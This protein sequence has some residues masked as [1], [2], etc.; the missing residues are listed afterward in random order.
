MGGV[1]IP[2]VAAVNTK[3]ATRAKQM[4]TSFSNRSLLTITSDLKGYIRIPAKNKFTQKEINSFRNLIAKLKTI[5]DSIFGIDGVNFPQPSGGISTDYGTD[6]WLVSNI[7]DDYKM[8]LE[9]YNVGD[10]LMDNRRMY[11]LLVQVV[12]KYLKK[13]MTMPDPLE[14]ET[15][16][17]T[18]RDVVESE[19]K[20]YIGRIS[21]ADFI[22]KRSQLDMSVSKINNAFINIQPQNVVKQ[23][24]STIL[25]KVK[26][27]RDKL[28]DKPLKGQ[29]LSPSQLAYNDIRRILNDEVSLVSG[30]GSMRRGRRSTARRTARRSRRASRKSSR[31]H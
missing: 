30:G 27:L 5:A 10:T 22:K 23:M 9:G 13:T 25:Q 11:Y 31:K 17:T 2:T 4:L 16:Y 6:Y 29:Y 18:L 24:T 14:L 8:M 3:D 19:L 28:A 15:A 20:P 21:S 12:Y 26:T 1:P 7:L